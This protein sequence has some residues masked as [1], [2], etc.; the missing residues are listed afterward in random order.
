MKKLFLVFIFLLFA[1]PCWGATYYMR[2]DGI[3]ANKAAASGPCGTQANCMSIAT[4]D[5]DTYSAGDTIILCD[6]GGTYRDQMDI[7]SSGSDGSPI[8]YEAASGDDPIIS[9]A[10][11]V[12]GWTTTAVRWGENTADDN[13]GVTEDTYIIGGASSAVNYDYT[14]KL[15]TKLYDAA[16]N[17]SKKIFL[18]FDLSGGT[19]TPLAATLKVKA[20][21]TG[22]DASTDTDINLC[23]RAWAEVTATW[24]TYD[25]ANAWGANHDESTLLLNYSTCA[26]SAWETLTSAGIL[27]ALQNAWGASDL[28]VSFATD[29]NAA[30][31]YLA[32]EGADGSRPYLITDNTPNLYSAACDWTPTQVFEDNTRLDYVTWDTDIATTYAGMSAGTWTLDDAN[33]LLYVWSS[34]DADPDTHTM[35]VS[36]R[37]NGI[38]GNDKSYITADGLQVEKSNGNSTF[39]GGIAD[40][41]SAGETASTW[42]VQNC[43]LKQNRKSGMWITAESS[44]I[45]GNTIYDNN[46]GIMNT[47]SIG[48]T[49]SQN[50]IYENNY[51]SPGDGIYIENTDTVIENNTIYSND[52]GS[53]SDNINVGAGCSGVIIRYNLLKNGGSSGIII[54]DGASDTEVYYNILMGGGTLS[55][56]VGINIWNSAGNSLVYNNTI[57]NDYGNILD[58]AFRIEAVQAGG[59][60]VIKNNVVHAAS[61]YAL[62][63]DGS[64]DESLVTLDNNCFYNTSGNMIQWEGVNYTQAQFSDYQLA[65]GED[66]NSISSDPLF[67]NAG[68]G[69][70]TLRSDSPCIEKGTDVGITKDFIGTYVPQGL[71]PDIGAFEYIVRQDPTEYSSGFNF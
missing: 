21:N 7:P 35:E 33:N 53:S 17:W 61:K 8:T 6:D 22:H 46:N 16:G 19:G 51:W 30:A 2:A 58:R 18:R 1:S 56:D 41:P 44:T 54:T 64:A 4:H 37:D 28:N 12:T 70:F 50:T 63:E 13:N 45:T 32:S 67:T 65:S 31:Y 5:A 69:D 55:Y 11:L 68:G 49:I 14:G 47:T 26:A 42:V 23:T 40:D 66:T 60:A 15:T 3:A 20:N 62:Y 27:T 10:D 59:T 25:G 24:D 39:D 29:A 36:T 57:Y 38:N 52:N 71:N 34:D 43:I 9:G 48:T